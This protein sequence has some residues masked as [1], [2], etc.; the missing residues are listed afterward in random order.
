MTYT[1]KEIFYTLQGEGANAGRAAVFCR[2]AGCNLWTGREDDRHRAVCTF[3][4]TDFVGTD[5][6]GGGKF[7][8]AA[9]LLAA[10]TSIFKKGRKY[11]FMVIT[12]L[13]QRG[14]REMTRIRLRRRDAFAAPGVPVPDELRVARERSRSRELA[15]IEARPQPLHRVAEGGDAALARHPR[16]GGGAHDHPHPA[17]PVGGDDAGQLRPR[18]VGDPQRGQHARGFPSTRHRHDGGSPAVHGKG[19]R[20]FAERTAGP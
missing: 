2:F 14:K 7:A 18:R 5:G 11:I 12:P 10:T 15:R 3:C 16:A 20:R 13:L 8:D 17:G 4:D 19:Y 1:V 6:P 9:A